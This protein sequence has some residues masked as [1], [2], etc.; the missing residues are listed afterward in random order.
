MVEGGV[1]YL[2]YL[3][4][5]LVLKLLTVIQFP[6]GVTMT[7]IRCSICTLF[8]RIFFVKSFRYAG[9]FSQKNQIHA[10][11]LISRLFV[12]YAI[13]FLNIAWCLFVIIAAAALCTPFEYNWN[14]SLPNGKCGNQ[15]AIYVAIAAW[16]IACDSLMW[17]LPIPF[18]WKL[19]I[20]REPKIAL[21]AVFALGI[22]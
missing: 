7:L 2:V 9:K 19:Q 17:L 14:K 18:V 22:L 10:M 16:A 13:M 11:Y 12:A 1:R 8:I 5:I 6:Y 3:L 20:R 21:S 15:D 4:N